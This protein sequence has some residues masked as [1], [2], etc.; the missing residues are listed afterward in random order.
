MENNMYN[1]SNSGINRM[2]EQMQ[3][4]MRPVVDMINS[5][6]YQNTIK[7]ATEVS[8]E[9]SKIM[10]QYLQSNIVENII[11]PTLTLYQNQMSKVLQVI[12]TIM[13]DNLYNTIAEYKN[14][15]NEIN[16]DN[17]I[18]N[19]N[20]TIEYE[21]NIYAEDE[22]EE[23]SD[24]I[25]EEINNKGK[26]EVET[27]LKK[28]IFCI[29]GTILISF[30]Q[31]DDLKYLFL[32]IF[33]GFL[34]QPGADAYTFLKDKFIKVF[35]KESITNDYFDNYSGLVQIDNLKLRKKPV[36]DSKVIANLEF[37]SSI[38]I[39]NQLGSWIE[40]NYCI[41][42]DNNTYISG[43][44]YANGIKRINKIKDKLLS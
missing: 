41:A 30:L 11:K 16:F 40:I 19:N 34:S 2:V 24:E 26:F 35:K 14:I 23:T 42:E 5:T 22:I 1:F 44:V 12:P 15:L 7:L 36:K 10:Q 17:V 38:E 25:I 32:M 9:S 20:G 31:T 3:Q 13:P 6:A 8:I 37:G 43:W 39:K 33:S 4:V 18:I 27:F 28:L 21:G 29:L